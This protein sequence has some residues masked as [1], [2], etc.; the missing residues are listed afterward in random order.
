MIFNFIFGSVDVC[1]RHAVEAP[2]RKVHTRYS[3]LIN[4]LWSDNYPKAWSAQDMSV[5]PIIGA[6]KVQVGVFVCSLRPRPE[7]FKVTRA[8]PY[9]VGY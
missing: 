4:Q 9:V 1:N 7:N 3:D 5:V 2:L 8:G 6:Q